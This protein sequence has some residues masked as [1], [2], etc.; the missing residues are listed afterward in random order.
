MTYLSSISGHCPFLCPLPALPF[1]P[2]NQP[3][4]P[5]FLPPNRHHPCIT[6]AH[7]RRRPLSFLSLLHSTPTAPPLPPSPPLI[8]DHR[9]L[10][11]GG[12]MLIPPPP[13]THRPASAIRRPPVPWLPPQYRSAYWPREEKTPVLP[14]WICSSADWPVIRSCMCGWIGWV[15]CVVE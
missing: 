6:T 10:W 13:S 8:N 11:G 15:D 9:K 5:S 7:H 1:P 2:P 3:P 12:G 14:A 4:P